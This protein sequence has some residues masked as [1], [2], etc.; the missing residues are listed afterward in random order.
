MP[1]AH[2]CTLYLRKVE[3]LLIY[4]QHRAEIHVVSALH[5]TSICRIPRRS[6]L[7]TDP[8][9]FYNLE[10]RTTTLQ[11]ISISE[12]SHYNCSSQCTV[13]LVYNSPYCLLM[14][15]HV[16]TGTYSGPYLELVT[17]EDRTVLIKKHCRLNLCND[18][19]T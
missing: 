14:H 7:F 16:Y 15:V 9:T 13:I 6:S 18:S 19:F 8:V 17:C 1:S 3:L 2:T 10:L 11:S 12:L 4:C 5:N